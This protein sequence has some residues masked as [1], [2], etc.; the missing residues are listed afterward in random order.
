MRVKNSG[1]IIGFRIQ[2]SRFSTEESH[3]IEESH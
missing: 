1:L 2:G 3:S